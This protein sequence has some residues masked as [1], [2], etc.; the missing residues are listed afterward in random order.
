MQRKIAELEKYFAGIELPMQPI[1]LDKCST[2]MNCSLFVESHLA[3]IK[4]NKNKDVILPYLH[5][6]QQ[7]KQVLRA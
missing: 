6:L 3:V 1:R 4:A 7:L 5:R 2:I